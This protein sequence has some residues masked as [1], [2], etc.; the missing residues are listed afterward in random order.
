MLG[1]FTWGQMGYV[2]SAD[3]ETKRNDL[4]QEGRLVR[5]D[6]SRGGSIRTLRFL[7]FSKMYKLFPSIYF[8]F[9]DLYHPESFQNV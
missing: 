9:F 2:L 6:A 1:S 5:F 7:D 4:L 3:M 8:L